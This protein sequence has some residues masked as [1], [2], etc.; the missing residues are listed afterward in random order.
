M[1]PSDQADFDTDPNN[2][3]P[4]R[5][6]VFCGGPQMLLG[7]TG[8]SSP[9]R[10]DFIWHGTERPDDPDADGWPDLIDNC[11]TLSNPDQ[12][13]DDTDRIGNPCDACPEW[14]NAL[15][16]QDRNGDNIPDDCQCGDFNGDGF[17]TGSDARSINKCSTGSLP[18][19]Q[20]PMDLL[21][22]NGD[23]E[24][25]GSDARNVN[26]GSTGSLETYELTCPRRPSGEPPPD[27]ALACAVVGITCE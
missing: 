1:R 16:L 26:K 25:T 2:A 9:G 5:S 18:E 13:D 8:E 4:P 24:L 15:P 27:L 19:E 17:L 7:M 22:V 23:G 12:A 11:P 20:C 21:D 6:P 10:R 3:I 14:P